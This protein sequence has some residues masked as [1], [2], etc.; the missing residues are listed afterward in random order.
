M[1][2]TIRSTTCFSR[3][4][5]SRASAILRAISST[6]ATSR[7][8]S[9][10]EGARSS[11]GAPAAIRRVPST[12]CIS[13]RVKL[14]ASRRPTAT[15]RAKRAAVTS[16]PWRRS[17][18]E[19][20]RP[21]L[22]LGEQ[23]HREEEPLV[24]GAAGDAQRGVHLEIGGVPHPVGPRVEAVAEEG[25][26]AVDLAG[27]AL[28]E[29]AGG[30]QLVAA[31]G[32]DGAPP[33][34]VHLAADDAGE[35]DQQAVAEQGVDAEAGGHGE[36]LL[37]EDLLRRGERRLAG[38][39]LVAAQA[40]LHRAHQHEVEQHER[41]QQQQ[42][43]DD[44]Q[45]LRVRVQRAVQ[46]VAEGG[47]RQRQ[48][49]ERRRGEGEQDDDAQGSSCRCA[50][51]PRWS[52]G[53]GDRPPPTPA[54]RRGPRRGPGRWGCRPRRRADARGAAAAAAAAPPPTGRARRGRPARRG[55]RGPA[56]RSP[57][58]G[59]PPARRAAGRR[60]PRSGGASRAPRSP[61]AAAASSGSSPT[62]CR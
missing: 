29:E 31:R 41:Q 23:R 5:R 57:A 46:Q 4:S 37:A 8:S 21:L 17:C 3:T 39:P 43:V 59:R 18:G 20:A 56:G 19:L 58:S 50:R 22:L 15:R 14:L 12:S 45:P 49:E 24:A 7:A 62:A 27:D 38:R 11:D 16:S 28:G 32:V 40:V 9:S 26:A 61:G 54:P 44:H 48:Q 13:G 10:S 25:E 33:V 1:F 51:A 35:V 36:Q 52:A 30:E 6:A 34:E 53:R 2:S 47:A 42:G 60:R 55:R